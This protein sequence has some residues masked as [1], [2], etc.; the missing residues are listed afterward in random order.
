MRRYLAVD[1]GAESGRVIAGRIQDSRLELEEIHRFANTPLHT[2]KGLF[3]NAPALFDEIKHG[4]KEASHLQVNGIGIDTWGLDF[5]LLTEDG[6]L[7]ENPRHYRDP[8]NQGAMEEAF[9]TVPR[10]EI[11][12][13][14][15]VQ[16]MDFN[17]LYQLFRSG[18]VQ[19]LADLCPRN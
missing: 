2:E 6:R 18:P 5:G 15:G 13:A 17:S 8:K 1:L 9:R 16:F 4:L 7:V 3:W 11:F 19:L 14:T 12:E 10:E